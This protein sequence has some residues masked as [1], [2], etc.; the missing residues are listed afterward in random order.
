MGDDDGRAP[1]DE[2]RLRIAV[3]V[4]EIDGVPVGEHLGAGT[5]R[6]AQ[7]RCRITLSLTSQA[8]AKSPSSIAS[9]HGSGR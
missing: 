7:R 6:T 2:G 3:D 5:R 1:A 4:D 8:R 9:V